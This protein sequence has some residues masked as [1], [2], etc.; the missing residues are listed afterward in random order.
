MRFDLTFFAK[1][2]FLHTIQCCFLSAPYL[3]ATVNPLASI[4]ITDL[5]FI[6]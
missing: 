5:P 3:D 1:S 6:R 2:P 4:G